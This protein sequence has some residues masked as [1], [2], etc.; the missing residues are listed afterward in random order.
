MRILIFGGTTEGRKL[1]HELAKKGAS[2]TVCV[3]TDYGAEEQGD[4]PNIH[5]L[6]GRKDMQEMKKLL[7]QQELCIDATHPYATEVTK[8]LKQACAEENVPY[9]RLLREESSF[10][11][12]AKYVDT[13]KQAAFFLQQTKGNILLTTGAK[14]LT[15]FQEVERERLYPRVLPAAEN[16]MLCE[17]EGIP[18]RNIIAMQGP[19]GD[20]LNEAIME[21]FSIRYMVTKD[22]GNVGGFLEKI[23]AAKKKNVEIIIIRRPVDN[24]K[25]YEEILKISEEMMG[26]R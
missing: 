11:E 6:M 14:E 12:G 8:N 20:A 3:A 19:F 17:K 23:Q 9:L 24:G 15:D 25:T 22:G 13:A 1:S 7:S 16:I 10:V 5:V 26:C 2:V 4:F 18:R 21:Q